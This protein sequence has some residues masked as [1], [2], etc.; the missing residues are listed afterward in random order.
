MCPSRPVRVDLL[1]QR[2]VLPVN[3]TTNCKR[4][5]GYRCFL[6]EQANCGRAPSSPFRA[7]LV[8]A[9]GSQRRESTLRQE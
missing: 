2:E 7:Y 4:L 1:R 6:P 8:S 9:R 3:L 5:P